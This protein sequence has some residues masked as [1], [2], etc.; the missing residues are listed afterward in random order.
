M[1]KYK[2]LFITQNYFIVP[3]LARAFER[4]DHLVTYI[5]FEQRTE[6]LEELFKIAASFQ[7]D[8]VFTINH[9]G[10]DYQGR[11]LELLGKCRIPVVSWFVDRPEAFIKS[12]YELTDMLGIFCWDPSTE[13]YFRDKGLLYHYLPLAAD[14]DIFCPERRSETYTV[15]FVGSSWTKKIDK[16]IQTLKFSNFELENYSEYAEKYLESGKIPAELSDRYKSLIRL[17][18]TRLHRLRA[19]RNI[20]SYHPVIVG[21]LF[22]KHEL[23]ETH[24]DWLPRLDYERE[25]PDF[26]RSSRIN[27]NITSFQ[28]RSALNQRVYDVPATKSVLL[29]NYSKALEGMFEPGVEVLS[30][31]NEDEIKIIMDQC[32]NNDKMI[33][34]VRAAGLRRVLSCHT[35]DHRVREI[36]RTVTKWFF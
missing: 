2:I 4:S 24:F 18:A 12:S 10:L 27:F 14:T 35:Y 32:M 21:D 5:N 9:A 19:L 20:I 3:E 28:S 36:V 23:P 25:L 6:F 34:R 26:Y 30:Y 33:K 11:V 8:F 22:W 31:K 16:K 17:E 7:P 15:S 29:T 1:K 13:E